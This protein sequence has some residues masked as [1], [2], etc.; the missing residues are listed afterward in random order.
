[1]QLFKI[2]W[3]G[4]LLCSLLCVNFEA[5]AS[6]TAISKAENASAKSPKI[7]FI[8]DRDGISTIY[9]MNADGSDQ[10]ALETTKKGRSVSAPQWTKDGKQVYFSV[11][12]P[13]ALGI[14]ELHFV[15][16]DDSHTQI[17]P[18][19]VNFISADPAVSAD[20]RYIA[21]VSSRDGAFRIY[22]MNSDG[23]N[24]HRLTPFQTS[25]SLTIREQIAPQW[26]PTENLLAFL[27]TEPESSDLEIVNFDGSIRYT[28]VRGV[29][30][31]DWSP[32]GESLAFISSYPPY[33]CTLKI[34][35]KA[36]KCLPDF[37]DILD[38]EWSPNGKYIAF[39]A[40]HDRGYDIY[41]L[42][43]ATNKIRRL[44]DN[45]MWTDYRVPTNYNVTW[46]P[47]SKHLSFV[48]SDDIVAVTSQTAVI[49]TI[50]VD[51]TNLK[52]LT[53]QGDK[54]FS[55]SWQP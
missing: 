23:S 22:I 33:I 31:F 49:Y 21:Y 8:S 35:D 52:P 29:E 16:I 43:V 1:M 44:T 9:I 26:S 39:S 28:V 2:T 40:S 24:D 37:E 36:Q 50:D 54:S 4:I 20:N 55:P 45:S 51:G 27:S 32:N 38:I 18:T 19:Q 5:Y 42:E 13:V 15:R 14:T 41:L 47:D 10:H 34:S 25:D 53:I 11:S 12:Y 17:I 48:S 3:I 30:G 46:S 6:E 7:A